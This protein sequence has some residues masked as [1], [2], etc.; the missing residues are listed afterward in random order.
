M[1]IKALAISAKNRILSLS[2]LVKLILILVVIGGIWTLYTNVS[3]KTTTAP[4]YQ[5]ATVEKGT[6]IV[7][8]AASG[9]ISNANSGSISTQASG[10]V[11]KIYV[12]NGETV[13]Q[14]NPIAELE[15]D[16]TARQNYSQALASYQSAKNSV[17]SAKAGLFTQN[18][19][20][21]T[22]WKKFTDL[23]TNSFYTNG[24]GSPNTTNRDLPE[25]RIAQDN[26]LASETKSKNQQNVLNQAQTSLNAAW[27]SLQESSSVIYA[28]ISGTV[29]GLSLQEGSVLTTQTASTGTIT[30]QK[31]ASIKTN[32]PPTLTINLTEIDV[33]NVKIGNK[34]TVTL[35]S[36]PDKSY[37]GQVVSIDTVGSVSSGVTTYPTVIKF[38]TEVPEIYSNMSAQANIITHIKNDVLIVPSSSVT[39][40]NGQST[41]NVL[42]NNVVTT[43]TVVPGISSST[44]TEIT[45]G[46]SEND[47][48]VTSTTTNAT[49]STTRTT[50]VFSGLGGGGGFRIAR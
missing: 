17:E 27:L 12:K 15:L 25:F 26:W 29:T 33:P 10:V 21:Y 16:Q 48:I 43:V 28:P 36:F 41:V 31:V 45:S 44:Q 11:T 5:T 18:A 2:P 9:Q 42:K 22:T 46:L 35:S 3:K 38:D 7:S 24:D 6:L 34:A 47:T 30:S 39:T 19:D 13:V 4:Q 14:G 37:T 8:T 1:N 50:S 32:A 20:L 49:T 23:A 40:L